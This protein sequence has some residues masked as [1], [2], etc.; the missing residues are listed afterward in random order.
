VSVCLTNN[1]FLFLRILFLPNQYV[2]TF[3]TVNETN[4]FS[5]STPLTLFKFLFIYWFLFCFIWDRVLLY[6]PGWPVTHYVAQVG[7]KLFIFPL[8]HPECWDYRYASPWLALFPFFYYLE[9]GNCIP[10]I[11]ALSHSW[12]WLG[13]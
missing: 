1:V 12:K 10:N 6:S 5:I 4:L 8:Q 3:I 7:L 2:M 9:F 13:K 11:E